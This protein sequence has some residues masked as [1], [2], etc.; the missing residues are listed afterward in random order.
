MFP[1]PVPSNFK[2][3]QL[4]VTADPLPWEPASFDVVHIRLV[5]IHL[6]KPERVLERLSRLVKPGGWLLAEDITVTGDVTGDAPAVR[7]AISLLYK[8]WESNG[9]D[10]RAGEKIESWLRQA[11]SFSEVNVHEV[12]MP[13]GNRLSATATAT[14]AQSAVQQQEVVDSKLR[15][16]ELAFTNSTRGTF[17][18][19]KYHPRM[20]ELGFTPEAKGQCLEQFSTSEWRMDMP[21]HFVWARKSV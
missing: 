17:A 1:R 4:D 7:T 10:P 8:S 13:V 3:Q 12:I 20:V 14:A 18:T 6:P 16:L 5:L 19:E 9:Q 11:G 2:F 21:L 15:A